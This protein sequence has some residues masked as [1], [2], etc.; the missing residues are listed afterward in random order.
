MNC[1][2]PGSGHFVTIIDYPEL[3]ITQVWFS[4]F[5]INILFSKGRWSQDLYVRLVGILVVIDIDCD[6]DITVIFKG[7]LILKTILNIRKR[8]IIDSHFYSRID[9]RGTVLLL[10]PL[11]HWDRYLGMTAAMTQICP[12]GWDESII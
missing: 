12:H 5:Y 8:L 10:H 7:T 3:S 1:D 4:G 11:S 6:Q 9:N 2:T